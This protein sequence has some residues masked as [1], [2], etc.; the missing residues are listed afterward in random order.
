MT[1][2]RFVLTVVCPA[3]RGIVAAISTFLAKN[4]CNIVNSSQF[5]DALSKKFFCRVGFDSEG[6][7]DMHELEKAFEPIAR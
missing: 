1:M 4:T 7:K 5:D 6:G 2:S 3:R